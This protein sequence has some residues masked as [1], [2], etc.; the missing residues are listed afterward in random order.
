MNVDVKAVRS[1]RLAMATIALVA[2][3]AWGAIL[4]VPDARY[5]DDWVAA[6]DPIGLYHDLG[7][8]WMGPVVQALF[9]LGPWAFKVLG[10]LSVIVVGCA[11]YV[12]AGRGLTL[13]SLERWVVAALIV[14]LPLNTARVS[15]AVLLTYSASLAVFMIAW[16][17]VVSKSPAEPGRARYIVAAVLF[18]ASFSTA[19]LL[20]FL[21]V[22]ATHL[23]LLAA[24]E[25]RWSWR[26][27]GRLLARFWYLALAPIAF[28]VLRTLYF[29]PTALYED[30]NTFISL[31]SPLSGTARST[32]L[33]MGLV[34]FTLVVLIVWWRWRSSRH[35]SAGA[36][37]VLSAACGGL[38]MLMRALGG[39]TSLAWIA[40]TALLIACAIALAVCGIRAIAGGEN[41][42][43]AGDVIPLAAGGLF[44]VALGIL[45][46]LVVDKLP[47]YQDWEVRHQLLMPFGLAV[48]ATAAWRSVGLARGRSLVAG[49]LVGAFAVVSMGTTLTLVADWRKQLV[50]IDAIR[51]SDEIEN[52]TTVVFDDEARALNFSAR[53]MSRFEY[54]DWLTTAFGEKNRYGLDVANVGAF[55][56]VDPEEFEALGTRYG[57]PDYVYSTTDAVL[58]EIRQVPGSTWWDLLIGNPAIEVAISPIDD[59]EALR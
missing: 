10:L 50:V 24:Q 26:M 48:L 16:A 28:W 35:V 20:L 59:L 14:A 54:G 23:L 40:V 51:A 43:R 44:L 42:T 47:S 57:H 21:V 22:P 58:V 5:W 9:V 52:V 25:W 12:V 55:L 1:D 53:P 29:P 17:L 46:Y 41:A 13:T 36:L 39:T 18:F 19:S 30:Y 31:T 27:V 33:L 3:V 2:I 37:L 7:L 38:V 15:L 34:V 49:V 6:N 32:V 4:L 45:P 8:P 11:A 56:D